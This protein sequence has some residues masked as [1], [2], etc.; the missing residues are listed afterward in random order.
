LGVVVA[1]R[2]LLAVLDVEA[3]LAAVEAVLL[4]LP[5]E[6]QPAIKI[7]AA[8]AIGAARARLMG[9]RSFLGNFIWL[10]FA[11]RGFRGRT[12][13]ACAAVRKRRTS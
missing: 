9:G 8:Q 6:P 5:E 12:A 4:E 2:P 1:F 3:V 13:E 11:Y 10:T 7:T